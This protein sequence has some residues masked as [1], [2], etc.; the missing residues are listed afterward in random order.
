MKKRMGWI[1]ALG[2]AIVLT[3]CGT[4]NQVL[5]KE[6]EEKVALTPMVMV[7]G[8]LYFDTGKESTLDGRCGT[9]DGEITSAVD[10]TERPTKN[11]QS[12]FGVGFPYQ[13]GPEETIEL[14]KE[15]KWWV[16][17]SQTKRETRNQENLAKTPSDQ[18]AD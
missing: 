11:D 2:M 15:G 17:E 3:G 10:C 9:L 16:Y 7:D 6:P 13:Y 4:S 1:L 14:E 12:N 8:E 18:A 5:Q